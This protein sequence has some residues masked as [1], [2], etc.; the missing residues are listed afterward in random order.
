MMNFSDNTPNTPT[1]F[2]TKN[3]VDL[4]NDA[5]GMYNINSQIE[6]KTSM[7][8]SKSCDIVIH[9]YLWVEV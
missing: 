5:R 3:W 1:K 9:I 8:N 7:L 4:S 2:R 6:F